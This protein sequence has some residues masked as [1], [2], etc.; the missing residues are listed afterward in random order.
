MAWQLI[1]VIHLQEAEE[2]SVNQWQDFDIKKTTSGPK[3]IKHLRLIESSRSKSTKGLEETC[4]ATT[5][6]C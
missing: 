1:D 5:D 3:I 4:P 2:A 6:L